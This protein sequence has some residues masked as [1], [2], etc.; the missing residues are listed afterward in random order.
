[1]TAYNPSSIRNVILAGHSGSG[2]TTLAEAMLFESGMITRRGSIHEK[3]TVSDFHPIEKERE[4]SLFTS[5]LHLDWRG[6]K[7]NLLDTPGTPD[8][9]GE[10]IGSLP[11]ADSILFTLNAEAGVEVTTSTLW[12]EAR[13]LGLPALIT[14][15]RLDS[16]RSNFQR[17]VDM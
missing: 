11:V 14:V 2:K 5:L 7:I 4:K 15:N 3:S 8:F 10:V 17:C 13:S 12:K 9:Y 6:V 1:M 16:P